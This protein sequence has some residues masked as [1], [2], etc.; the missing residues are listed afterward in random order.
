MSRSHV[1]LL[2]LALAAPL[3]LAAEK[4]AAPA[5]KLSAP[6]THDNITVFLILGEDQIKGDVLTLAEAMADKKVVVHETKTVSQLSIENT[7]DKQVFIQAGDIVKGGQQDRTI[8]FDI[9]LPAKS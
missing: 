2:L 6:F 9:L 8:A 1:A 3:A 5:Y 4:K 7:S